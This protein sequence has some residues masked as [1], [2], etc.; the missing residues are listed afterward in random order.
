MT[1]VFAPKNWTSGDLFTSTNSNANCHAE[2]EDC[3]DVSH[4]SPEAPTDPDSPPVLRR[5][6]QGM[7]VRVMMNKMTQLRAHFT[8]ALK[9]G[10]IIPILPVKFQ[11]D[12]LD[13]RG[14]HRGGGGHDFHAAT[15]SEGVAALALALSLDNY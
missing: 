10:I 3:A 15:S 9:L 12:G 5:R 7:V 14:R 4:E 6:G 8:F 1:I 2:G 13:L 11:N